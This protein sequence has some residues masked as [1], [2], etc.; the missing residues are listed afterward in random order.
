MKKAFITLTLGL[1]GVLSLGSSALAECRRGVYSSA[2]SITTRRVYFD[3]Y[4][5]EI[6]NNYRSQGIINWNAVAITNPDDYQYRACILREENRYIDIPEIIIQQ[7]IPRVGGY[8]WPEQINNYNSYTIRDIRYGTGRSGR[9]FALLIGSSYNEDT[10][11]IY[12]ENSNY[13]AG[14]IQVTGTTEMLIPF[15]D[16]TRSI[17]FD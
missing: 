15:M 1:L 6:P 7:S 3:N 14:S 10:V 16:I 8:G 9:D 4:S 11:H 2:P 5:F 13:R 12:V 17:R